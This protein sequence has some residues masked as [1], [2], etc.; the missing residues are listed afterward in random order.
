M[1]LHRSVISIDSNI[2]TCLQGDSQLLWRANEDV[3]VPNVDD[4]G[5]ELP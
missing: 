1:H 5:L 3:D 4:G 2:C